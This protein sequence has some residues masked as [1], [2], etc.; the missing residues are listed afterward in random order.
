MRAP[1]MLWVNR[2]Y[3]GDPF[4]STYDEGA[5]TY[6]MA[7]C[8]TSSGNIMRVLGETPTHYEVE[9][10]PVDQDISRYD[11]AQFNWHNYPWIFFKAT[12]RTRDG[13]IQNVGSGLDVYHINV[14]KPTNRHYIHK[15]R[16]SLFT[17]PPFTV[18]YQSQLHTVID[19]LF[20]GA[21]VYGITDADQRVPLLI[22]DKPGQRDYPT[23]WRGPGQTVI[24]PAI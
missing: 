4:G 21:S 10:W 20:I 8:I 16:L 22:A 18:S 5:D 3:L 2:P 11:P 9:A 13:V 15:S 12:A 19:Y 17:R 24:P 14:R 23:A 7:E 6:P 1:F